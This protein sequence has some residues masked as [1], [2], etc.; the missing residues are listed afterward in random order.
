MVCRVLK[1][2]DGCMWWGKSLMVPRMRGDLIRW[3][4]GLGKATSLY[5]TY[6]SCDVPEGKELL[7]AQIE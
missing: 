3:M 6:V 2:L 4:V 5:T 7:S 1:Y